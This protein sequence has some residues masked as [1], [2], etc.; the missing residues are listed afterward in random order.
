MK[1][2]ASVN[3]IAG[4]WLI[5]APFVLAYSVL[6]PHALDN[7]VTVGVLLILSSA[8]IWVEAIAKAGWG[9]FDM[10]CGC[11]LVFAPFLLHYSQ[12]SRPTWNDGIV[13]VVVL[14]ASVIQTWMTTS[15]AI[16]A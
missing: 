3:F 13:G 5:L 7:D 6:S 11:W 1:R 2:A 4:A 8:S 16:T 12:F 9:W 14:G 10:A 15:R